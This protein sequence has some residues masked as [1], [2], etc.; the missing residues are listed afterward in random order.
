MRVSTAPSA[1]VGDSLLRR[2]PAAAQGSYPKPA[3]PLGPAH[4]TQPEDK[5]VLLHLMLNGTH[6]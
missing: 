3:E 2:P 5:E 4:H 1:P 6:L